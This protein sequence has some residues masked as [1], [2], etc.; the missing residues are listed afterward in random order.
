[1]SNMRDLLEKMTFAGQAV[2]QKPGDQVRGSEP[3]PKKGGGKKHPY[4]G[5][6][7]GDGGTSE[8]VEENKEY[9]DACDR[10]VSQCVCDDKLKESLVQEFDQYLAEYGAQGS[11]IGNDT[12]M[13]NADRVAQAQQKN[14]GNQEIKNQVAGL[15]AQVTGARAQIAQLNKQ[16]P[17]GAN[18]VEKAMALRDM[19][20]QRIGLQNQIEDLTSQIAAL[21]QQAI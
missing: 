13:T 9:C 5:R 12:G 10:V 1:M 18:P 6:L 16:F 15:V 11:A 3:M 14:A 21:R 7:V 4:A 19:Q 2:G 17:Q 8:S 20:G